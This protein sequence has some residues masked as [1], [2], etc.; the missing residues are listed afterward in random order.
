MKFDEECYPLMVRRQRDKEAYD[1]FDHIAS[2]Y[3]KMGS[4]EGVA[5]TM[6]TYMFP[7]FYNDSK[8]TSNKKKGEFIME[9]L[10]FKVIT[11][12]WEIL[13]LNS[14][15]TTDSGIYQIYGDSP[16]YGTN[17]LLYIG[18]AHNIQKRINE[19]KASGSVI[20]RQS[21]LSIRVAKIDKT[22]LDIAESI[23]IATHKPSINSEY[24][25]M[26]SDTKQLYM[27]QNHGE[28]GALTLQVTNS[29][30]VK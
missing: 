12:H 29:Y 21:N 16:L 13:D 9:E 30:W 18:Q 17:V 11:L 14:D 15:L 24:L 6:A 2:L 5:K 4:D 20:A 7:T 19:H 27:I 28:R 1:I 8:K 23:L 22:L 3:L 10:T 26:P 25:N